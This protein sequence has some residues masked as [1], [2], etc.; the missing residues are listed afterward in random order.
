MTRRKR[1]YPSRE[2]KRGISAFVEP[3]VWR[4]LRLLAAVED[5]SV[6]VLSEEAIVALIDTRRPRID[7]LL[8][9]AKPTASARSSAVAAAPRGRAPR[10]HRHA[11]RA[12]GAGAG[13][14]ARSAARSRR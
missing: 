4:E 5:T 10:P 14:R 12:A 9:A 3:P 1:S 8:N 11:R 7:A 2:G 13:R 6:R